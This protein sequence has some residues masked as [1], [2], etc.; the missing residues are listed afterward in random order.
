MFYG[1]YRTGKVNTNGQ[2]L[3]ILVYCSHFVSICCVVWFGH[4]LSLLQSLY[5]SEGVSPRV[6]DFASTEYLPHCHSIGPL[7]ALWTTDIGCCI[8]THTHTHTHHSSR[9]TSLFSEK[10]PSPRLSGAIHFTGSFTTSPE[11]PCLK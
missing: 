6:W 8:H 2:E 7:W 11:L 9:T 5:E 1:V 10:W 4:P 3:Y